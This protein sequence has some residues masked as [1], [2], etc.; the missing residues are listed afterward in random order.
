MSL[1][2][3]TPRRSKEKP[4]DA[5]GSRTHFEPVCSRPPRRR[6][7]A[8]IGKTREGI[9]WFVLPSS[10]AIAPVN[11]IVILAARGGSWKEGKDA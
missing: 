1:D 11:V 4:R 6:A 3:H 7:S 5:D 9:E 10:V 8:S 2:Q